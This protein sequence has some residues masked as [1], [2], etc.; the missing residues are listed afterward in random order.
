MYHFAISGWPQHAKASS[1]AG[2]ETCAISIKYHKTHPES[3]VLT[4]VHVLP[5]YKHLQRLWPADVK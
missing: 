4:Y 1:C 5:M 3:S 2:F